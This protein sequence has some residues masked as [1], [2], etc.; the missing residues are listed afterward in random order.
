MKRLFFLLIL[1][2][3][4]LVAF[5]QMDSTST[6]NVQ[7][8]TLPLNQVEDAGVEFTAALL[9][10]GWSRILFEAGEIAPFTF[11]GNGFDLKFGT[12]LTE[13]KTRLSILFDAQH[14]RLRPTRE[15]HDFL[16]NSNFGRYE[17]PYTTFSWATTGS[18]QIRKSNHHL[19][20]SLLIRG[21]VIRFPKQDSEGID[22]LFN[23][24]EADNIFYTVAAYYLYEG[25]LLGMPLQV[26]ATLPFL[27]GSTLRKPKKYFNPDI[28]IYFSPFQ[29]E[30]FFYIYY[31]FT[32]T[33]F[34]WDNWTNH[35]QRRLHNAVGLAFMG[36][37]ED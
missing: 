7:I 10:V 20:G 27:S 31:Q 14:A 19:G 13:R 6:S 15:N 21:E 33:N 25:K 34:R 29:N 5:G 32:Y 18:L 2:F 35:H 4:E 8:D 23:E 30:S 11:M 3:T 22:A 12:A 26:N 36:K 1:I 24:F 28:R 17:I 9:S 37:A 16:T